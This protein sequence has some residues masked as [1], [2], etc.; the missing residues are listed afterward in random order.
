ME[1]PTERRMLHTKHKNYKFKTWLEFSLIYEIQTWERTHI[2][3]RPYFPIN[4]SPAKISIN[5]SLAK[6][7]INWSLWNF[8]PTLN[9]NFATG[10]TKDM[11]GPLK[12]FVNWSHRR[13]NWSS[14]TRKTDQN[15]ATLFSSLSSNST[16]PSKDL[17]GPLKQGKPTKI[18]QLC[19]AT[20]FP[21]TAKPA[22]SFLCSLQ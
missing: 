8:A 7:S 16:G 2:L 21:I 5:W 3:R 22:K 18:L 11:T 13:F 9:S 20:C 6:S 1:N 14:K 10:P 12:W 19:S 15:F 17:T 4:W